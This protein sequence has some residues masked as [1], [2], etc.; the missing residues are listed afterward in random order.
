M[1]L[2]ADKLSMVVVVEPFSRMAPPKEVRFFGLVL[3]EN[4][5]GKIRLC[6]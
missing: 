2:D 5:N 3:G 6:F 1:G 4:S